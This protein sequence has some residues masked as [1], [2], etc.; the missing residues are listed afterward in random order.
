MQESKD[1]KLGGVV[2]YWSVAR[3]TKRVHLGTLM[4]GTEWK[5]LVPPT[6]APGVVLKDAL[7]EVFPVR[8][9]WVEALKARDAFEVIQVDKGENQNIYR[10]QYKVSVSG[11]AQITITPSD[12]AL[13]DRIEDAFNK[14]LGMV[15]GSQV[16]QMLISILEKLGG[17]RLRKNGSVYWLPEKQLPRWRSIADAVEQSQVSNGCV[18]SVY[19]IRH[20]L[21]VE[22][23]RAVRDALVAEV[24]AE[25]DTIRKD[26]EEGELGAR[27]L[28]TRRQQAVAL[29][30]KVA[31]YESLLDVGLGFLRENLEKVE[32][33][34]ATSAILLAAGVGEEVGV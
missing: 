26:I 4:A 14:Y 30:R 20:S 28:N 8:H 12:T 3:F 27:A 10:H 16:T 29:R 11:G 22:E 2:T 1:L 5:A 23:V 17:I 32:E 13:L 19:V 18:N 31:E 25:A 15:S 34:E 9:Y 7:E 6:R 33:A 21:G 24:E